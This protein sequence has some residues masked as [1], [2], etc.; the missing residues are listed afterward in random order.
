[1]NHIDETP[2]LA[3]AGE[4]A[5][6]LNRSSYG[7]KKALSRLGVSP[8]TVLAGTSFYERKLAI[9]KLKSEMRAPNNSTR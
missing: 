1:M 7:V 6:A 4:L 5:K 3:T 8:K 9:G 2:T